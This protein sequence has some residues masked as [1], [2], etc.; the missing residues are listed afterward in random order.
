MA[1]KIKIVLGILFITILTTAIYVT[2]PNKLKMR[3]DN[4]KSTFYVFEDSRWK[5]SG[6]EYNSLFDGSSKMN[7]ISSKITVNIS[8]NE[9]VNTTTIIRITPYIRGPVIVDTYLFDGKITDK[10]LFPVYHTV[11]IFNGSGFF[12]RYEVRDLVYGGESKK[13]D[14]NYMEFGR[15]MKVEWTDKYRWARI[16][17]SG[18]LKVQYDI[19]SDY[20]KY[21]VKLFDPQIKRNTRMKR[22]FGF[23]QNNTNEMEFTTEGI[24]IIPMPS[25]ADTPEIYV[26]EIPPKQN[27]IEEMCV[28][29]FNDDNDMIFGIN[30]KVTNSNPN[31]PIALISARE[32]PNHNHF[33]IGL[34]GR[35]GLSTAQRRLKLFDGQNNLVNTSASELIQ[36]NVWYRL[37]TRL[38]KG[39]PGHLDVYLDG[40]EIFSQEGMF[41]AEGFSEGTQ[42]C[43][44]GQAQGGFITP[45]TRPVASTVYVS[46]GYYLGHGASVNDFAGEFG[47]W[48]G[49]LQTSTNGDITPGGATP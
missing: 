24:N 12:Y 10:E 49:H 29:L 38:T 3:I 45:F 43:L 17:K 46:A 8:I 21:K 27:G 32:G 40:D 11:E 28:D 48:E 30:F 25:P 23:E 19:P 33:V 26:A 9:S 18:I 37:E 47:V 14:T 5:V 16:Y 34:F 22:M 36:D 31:P 4:D 2:Y 42:L 13:L 15:N 6:R 1:L 44:N 35:E 41:D 20:E 39:N 7:R